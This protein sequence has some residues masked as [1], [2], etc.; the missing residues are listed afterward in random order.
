MALATTQPPD[1]CS[2]VCSLPPPWPPYIRHSEPT[3]FAC[4]SGFMAP[5]LETPY[6]TGVSF[7][8]TA[9][10]AK[11]G[12][13]VYAVPIYNLNGFGAMKV[14]PVSSNNKLGCCCVQ[15]NPTDP[16]NCV[17]QRK[18][19]QQCDAVGGIFFPGSTCD[20][21]GGEGGMCCK[22]R[23][24]VDMSPTARPRTTRET[25]SRQDYVLN[26]HAGTSRADNVENC[27]IAVD[28]PIPCGNDLYQN[29]PEALQMLMFLMDPQNYGDFYTGSG[30]PTP[31]EAALLYQGV[32]ESERF[33]NGTCSGCS[34][35]NGSGWGKFQCYVKT[36]YNVGCLAPQQS[37]CD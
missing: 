20:E 28:Q 15:G 1:P 2:R 3:A 22:Q 25:A 7:E 32:E 9:W 19:H 12:P 33:G 10:S 16:M 17:A 18:T 4:K 26:L 23:P 24:V 6:I 30:G 21:F 34:P 13:Y 37:N 5:M 27:W 36:K 29:E 8:P 14:R 35:Q 31:A 11:W